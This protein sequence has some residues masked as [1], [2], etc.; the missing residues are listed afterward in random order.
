[1]KINPIMIPCLCAALSIAVL[2]CGSAG[3][4]DEAEAPVTPPPETEVPVPEAPSA[5]TSLASLSALT[6]SAG[7]LVPAFSPGHYAYT[8][9]VAG[10]VKTITVTASATMSDATA[11]ISPAQPVTLPVGDTT[12]TVSVT[13]PNGTDRKEYQVKVTR[14]AP[15]PATA[16]LNS[17]NGHHYLIV[18]PMMT[19]SVGKAKCEEL[20]G[21]LATISDAAEKDFVKSLLA[22][23]P[24]GGFIGLNDAAT[25]GTFVW[26]TGEPRPYTNWSIGEPNNAGSGEHYVIML[27]SGSWNDYNATV[28]VP[29]VC[30]WDE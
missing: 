7:T 14:S 21:H 16:T 12:I 18:T 5:D 3:P 8:V 2:G 4:S 28:S 23:Y 27:T 11:S 20:S 24:S 13:A 17:A 29:A 6:V 10:S 9:A 19:W 25:E 26:V 15:Y 22:S 30:E 1:M